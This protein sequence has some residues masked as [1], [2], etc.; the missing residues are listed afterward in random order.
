MRLQV[1]TE[2]EGFDPLTAGTALRRAMRVADLSQDLVAKR[3]GIND[4]HLNRL[5]RGFRRLT[6]EM[7][8]RIRLAVEEL[9][10]ADV[11]W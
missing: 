11:Q 8:E 2:P 3:V 9:A 5:L 4:G 10:P 7:A 1:A 6:P